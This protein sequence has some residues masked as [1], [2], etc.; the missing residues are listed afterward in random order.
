MGEYGSCCL[1]TVKPPGIFGAFKNL[2][3][4]W[5]FGVSHCRMS[6]CFPSLT[7]QVSPACFLLPLSL[8]HLS[9]FFSSIHR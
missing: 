2:L 6:L 1:I 5:L 7:L 8:L 4:L 3:A 9:R